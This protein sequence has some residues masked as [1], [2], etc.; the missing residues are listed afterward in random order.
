MYNVNGPPARPSACH[1]TTLGFS[2]F[3]V[4]MLPALREEHIFEK[5]TKNNYQSPNCN[6]MNFNEFR[7]RTKFSSPMYDVHGPPARA[8]VRPPVRRPLRL[9]AHA[10]RPSARPS[11]CHHV[12]P[13]A[14][15]SVRMSAGRPTVLA[16]ICPMYVYIY[17][18]YYIYVN[19]V[20]MIPRRCC[21]HQAC[22][23]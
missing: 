7:V 19:N 16:H 1:C 22:A 4:V 20:L 2:T 3:W 14:R 5:H 13:S 18:I 21:K 15:P 10:A 9:S 23:G 11:A 17:R 8:S 6:C 12:R